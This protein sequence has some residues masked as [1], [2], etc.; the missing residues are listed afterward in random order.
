MSRGIMLLSQYELTAVSID[1][2]SF[3]HLLRGPAVYGH[4][5]EAGFR[6]N[7]QVLCCVGS[8]AKHEPSALH[9][10]RLTSSRHLREG[11]G[12]KVSRTKSKN[13]VG[14][15]SCVMSASTLRT[16]LGLNGAS[17]ADLRL[18]RNGVCI[19]YEKLRRSNIS[20]WQPVVWYVTAK[21]V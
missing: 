20:D 21:T 9:V 13:W 5:V 12:C 2:G 10:G 4:I 11:G 7:R 19:E 3:Q 6:Y 14:G 1:K 17:V 18:G 16:A 8:Q 15:E